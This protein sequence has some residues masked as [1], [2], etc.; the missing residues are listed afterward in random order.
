M[1]SLKTADTNC[2]FSP[3][4]LHLFPFYPPCSLPPA[5]LLRRASGSLPD[6]VTVDGDKL[7]VKKV[8]DAVN[9]TFIC[10]VENKHGTR[11]HQITTVVI[12]EFGDPPR[13]IRALTQLM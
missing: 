4:S 2:P 12:G 13:A 10:E 5:S 1:F 8:D 9:T 7:M 6:T 3:S 11:R